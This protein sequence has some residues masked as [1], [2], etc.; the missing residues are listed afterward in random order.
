MQNMIT[1]QSNT[2]CTPELKYEVCNS[3]GLGV[4][5]L[6]FFRFLFNI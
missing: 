5:L 4:V 6:G 1:E 3:K 2:D